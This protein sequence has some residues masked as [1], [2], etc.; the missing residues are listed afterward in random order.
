MR[1]NTERDVIE[2]GFAELPQNPTTTQITFYG[3]AGQDPG[4]LSGLQV[5][6]PV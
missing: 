4:D 6:D 3:W 5:G 1:E 2:I